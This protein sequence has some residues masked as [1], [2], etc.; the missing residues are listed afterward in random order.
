MIDYLNRASFAA[1]FAA[2]LAAVA[3]LLAVVIGVLMLANAYVMELPRWFGTW[4][5]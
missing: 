1:G 2:V 3:V 4:P 5:L